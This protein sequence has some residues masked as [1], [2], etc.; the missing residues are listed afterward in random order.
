MVLEL[1]EDIC[2]RFESED[3][4][5]GHG[6]DNAWDEAV[7]LV[8][9]C[10]ELPLKNSKAILKCSVGTENLKKVRQL[11]EQRIIDRIPL[12]YL[13]GVTWFAGIEFIT[14][15][16]AIIPRSPIAE[17][18]E[19]KFLPWYTGN[20]LGSM[21][22][23][24]CGGGC[25]GIASAILNPKLH[26]DLVDLDKNTLALARDNIHKHAVESRVQAMYS[27]IFSTLDGQYYDLIVS[28]PPYVNAEDLASIPKE[29]HHEPPLAL[30]SGADGLTLTREILKQAAAHLTTN[31]LLVVEVGNSRWA[32]E[33]AF[34]SVAF[35]WPDFE[36]GGH[37]V[38]VMSKKELQLYQESFC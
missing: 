28:N 35:T 32:L 20:E 33:E 9:H 1:I 21:L 5:F 27:D 25:I 14:D 3:L 10:M 26:V 19:K 36:R 8:L 38:F 22:D 2:Q 37:G 16:R 4:F 13:T 18:I 23:L 11:S 30:G 15:K 34:P 12:P 7:S 29:Y 17:L 24:C 31:G 6:T